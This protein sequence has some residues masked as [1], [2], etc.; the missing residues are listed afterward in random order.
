MSIEQDQ[1]IPVTDHPVDAR[2]RHF[3]TRATQA[4]GAL[5][6]GVFSLPFVLSMWPSTRA[7]AASGPVTVDLSDM[8]TGD[9]RTVMWQE[10]PVWIVKRSAQD[11][12]RLKKILPYLRDP[13]SKEPQQPDYARNYHRSISPEYL[14][15][16]GVCT[17][18]GCVPTYR[19]EPG[20]VDKNWKG[21]FFCSCHGSQFDLAGRVY[22]GVPAP[23]NL[24]VPPYQFTSPHTLVVGKH[25]Q[26]TMV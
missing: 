18:L 2:R 26:A 23:S 17:H 15:V 25:H 9:Q 14:V 7:K 24:E 16:V 19:P 11:V 6:V 4:M 20:S 1:D 21:G 3:L 12:T 5:G 13:D 22:T 8:K 10:K